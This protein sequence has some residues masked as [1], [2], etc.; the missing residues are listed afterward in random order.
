M[1]KLASIQKIESLSPIEGAD[2]I[3]LAHILGWQVIVKKDEFK[4]GDLCVYIEI[5]SLLPEKPEFEFLRPKGFKIKTMKMKGVISQG[6][7]FP[8]SILPK[9]AYKEEDDVTSIIGVTK[10]EK[11]DDQR[12]QPITYKKTRIP[13]FL[14][15]YSFFRKIFL[16]KEKKKGF[17]SWIR[18]T[19]EERIQTIPKILERYSEEVWEVS[20]KLDGTSATYGIRRN[21]P[22]KEFVICSRN[23]ELDDKDNHYYEMA[24]KYSIKDIVLSYLGK[25]KNVKK[26]VIQGE[27]I[28]PGIQKNKYN[29]K[30]KDL[31]IFNIIVNDIKMSRAELIELCILSGLKHVPY[32]FKEKKIGSVEEAIALSI[33]T[34]FLCSRNRE[35]IVCRL[36]NDPWT[37]FKVI[38]P[39]FLLEEK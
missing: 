32:L 39:N 29:L 8:L 10:Y 4:V 38:N 18:K 36:K 16:K 3:E 26:I 5:D 17:P 24:Q 31:Y 28:G 22:R 2:R 6:I 12:E 33:G 30:E 20:E 34:S 35:G 7:C 11:D 37:S 9:K 27:I 13:K 14:L 25:D 1:R 21:G 19:D 23:H 15:R